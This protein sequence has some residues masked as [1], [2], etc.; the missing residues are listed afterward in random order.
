MI[1][2]FLFSFFPSLALKRDENTIWR[3]ERKN[4]DE[5]KWTVES[6]ENGFRLW[7][8]IASGSN[9]SVWLFGLIFLH[10]QIYI[11]YFSDEVT[12]WET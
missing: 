12:M 10:F 5:K 9:S 8:R 2:E 11:S 7:V 4:R 1:F 3:N 6:K